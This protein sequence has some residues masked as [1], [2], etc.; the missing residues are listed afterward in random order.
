MRWWP[1]R[2]REQDLDRELRAH[3]ESEADERRELG[4][5][6]D[7][8]RFAAQRQLGNTALLKESVRDVWGWTSLDRAGQDIRFGLR[9][10]RKSPV[11]SFVAILS[12]ALGIGANTAIFDLIDALLLK[13]LPVHDPRSLLFLGTQENG[14]VATQFYYGTYQQ[15][16]AEQPFFQ[17]LAAYA[18]QVRMNVTIAGAAE[19]TAGQLV[20]GNYYSV[21]GIQPVAGRVFTPDDDRLPGAHPVAIVS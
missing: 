16:R 14:A 7:E 18:G 21:L 1:R 12:L 17:E 10:L 8:A 4:V 9:L 2:N 3:L 19:S 13:S 15:L 5:E 11:F 20:S 6:P